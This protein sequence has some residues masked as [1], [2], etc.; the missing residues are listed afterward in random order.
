[1][2][3]FLSFL[4]CLQLFIFT[5][6]YCQFDSTLAVSAF[7]KKIEGESDSLRF[8]KL[9]AYIAE[10]ADKL[11]F[12][13]AD[14]AAA[15]QRK[16]ANKTG[17]T[18]FAGRTYMS[19]GYIARQQDDKTGSISNYQKAQELF[20]KSGDV[21][22]EIR[23]FQRIAGI[24]ISNRDVAHAEQYVQR[25]LKLAFGQKMENEIAYLYTDQATVEDIRGNYNAALDYNQKAVNILKKI[26]EDHYVTLF[27][28]G[29]ILKNAG[30]FQESIGVY[31]ECLAYAQNTNFPEMLEM[32]Y[33]N[34]PYSLL[35]VGDT[36]RAEAYAKKV[37]ELAPGSF[38]KL[39][40]TRDAYDILAK[41]AL[42]RNAFEKAYNFQLKWIAYRDSVFNL[43]T[44]R[45]LVEAESKFQV[46]EKQQEIQRLDNENRE[47]KLQLFWLTAGLLLLAIVLFIAVW[48]Y[49]VIRRVNRKLEETNFNLQ[50][51]NQQINT[52]SLQLKELMQELHHRVK[53]NLAIVSSLLSLQADRLDDQKAAL[54]VMEGQQR[55][56]A[57]S[58]IHNQLY[59]TDNVTGV[60]MKEYVSDLTT[61]LMQSFRQ[62]DPFHMRLDIEPIVLDV[63]LA[64]PIG[65]IINELTTNAFKHA[66]KEVEEAELSIRLW[67][68][69]KMYLEI[70]DN[71]P[72]IAPEDWQKTGDSFGK[73]LIK[74]LTKQAKGQI[75]VFSESGSRFLLS[76]PKSVVPG[77][78]DATE[79]ILV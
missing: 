69:D 55:V 58:L 49:L 20:R 60:N 26:G 44:N 62:G 72:G 2:R 40:I 29:I 46:K 68:E 24:Y 6:G 74:S 53:N 65:L 23:S 19:L 59:L 66:Y 38:N 41:V 54:A 57:M 14:Q 1:M 75:A 45:Q 11:R 8:E 67:N 31:E 28:R 25:A 39:A 7:L 30:R 56:E 35:Q 71:G 64:V 78:E 63:E 50:T 48:Q 73:R 76:F 10:T 9:G 37:L 79:T 61:G 36:E 43:E 27:N 22:R 3:V 70:K 15:E 52:Q 34:M 77:K 5:N 12:V 18:G 13:D 21:K 47:R 42:K 33:V 4:V 51:A 17:S 32:I 16:I